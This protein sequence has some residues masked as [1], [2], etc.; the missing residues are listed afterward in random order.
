MASVDTEELGMEDETRTEEGER[1]GRGAE[2]RREERK[3]RI[4]IERVYEKRERPRDSV[5]CDK[6]PGL[7]C[8]FRQ[9]LV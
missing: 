1:K 5:V 9:W 7:A 4:K 3:S 8:S 2:G 6:P